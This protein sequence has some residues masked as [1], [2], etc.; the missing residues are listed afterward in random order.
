MLR[1]ARDMH[2]VAIHARDGIVGKLDEVLFDDVHWTVRYLVADTG[3]WLA[4]RKVLLAPI[5]IGFTNW[6]E[7]RLNNDHT[8]DQI[9]NSPDVESDEPVSRQWEAKY[10]GYYGW[11]YYW[12]GPGGWGSYSFLGATAPQPSS[13]AGMPRDYAD[14]QDVHGG[15]CHLRSSREVTGYN[16]AATDGNVGHVDDFIVDDETWCI[17]YLAVDTRVIWPDK[18]VLLP[19]DWIGEVIWP[20]RAVKVNVSC[21][22]IKEAPEW[23]QKVPISP[24][25]EDRLYCYT[26]R[27]S[28][29]VAKAEAGPEPQ[30]VVEEEVGD[31]TPMF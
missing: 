8:R 2:G 25:F 18:K 9:E 15:D 29:T 1:R 5:A 19:L 7:S 12:A 28:T 6:E 17:R 3:H 24:E 31:R 16:I 22:Q 23:E 27:Q 10:Y 13:F 4:S 26:V 30:P 11:P 20:D 21:D 14:K